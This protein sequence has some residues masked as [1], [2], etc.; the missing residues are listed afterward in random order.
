MQSKLQSAAAPT[1]GSKM[2][3]KT[4]KSKETRALTPRF[5]PVNLVSTEL[6]SD[7]ENA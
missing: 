7:E 4:E 3:V 5:S 1:Q 2:A 6:D